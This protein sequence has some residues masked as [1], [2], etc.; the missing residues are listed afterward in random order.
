[1]RLEIVRDADVEDSKLVF[2]QR[3]GDDE[4]VLVFNPERCS[5]CMFCVYACPVNAIEFAGYEML[6]AGMP[7]VIDHTACCF[8]GI[9]YA[10]CPD[11]AFDFKPEVDFRLVGGARKLEGCVNCRICYEVCPVKAINVKVRSVDEFHA[12]ELGESEEIKGPAKRGKLRIDTSRCKLCGK[13][14]LFC[15]AFVGVEKS[16]SPSSPSPF[17]EILFREERCDYCGLCE[18]VCPNS[19][20]EVESEFKV[21]V[22]VGEVVEV[23]VTEKCVE[24]GLCVKACP[25]DGVRLERSFSGEVV[26]HWERL[27]RTCDWESCRLCINVCRSKAWYVEEGKLRFEPELCRFCRA[28]MYAC[29]E[30]LIEVRLFDVRVNCGWEGWRKAVQRVLRE[31]KA[32]KGREIGVEAAL[33]ESLEEREESYERNSETVEEAQNAMLKERLKGRLKA[34]E[35]VLKNSAYRRL[36]ELNPEKFLEVFET[37]E[38]RSKR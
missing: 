36:F 1:M 34:L 32:S 22:E 21:D 29:P 6:L 16:M 4:R 18:Q 25:Y 3:V 37:L 19:A 23:E 5:G 15:D 38:C 14:T 24:C 27:E 13:C 7:L 12:R 31:E 28:C 11:R 35:E 9:C 33:N 2:R 8:C 26:V 20:I 30:R 10:L 17:S